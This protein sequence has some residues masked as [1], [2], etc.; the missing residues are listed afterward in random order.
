VPANTA[1]SIRHFLAKKNIPALSHPPY[2]PAL[3]PCDFYLFLK[4]KLKLKGH[5]F[6]TVTNEERTHRK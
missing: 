3:A 1:L 5:Y 6:G 4:L 2:S